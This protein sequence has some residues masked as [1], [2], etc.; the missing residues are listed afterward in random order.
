MLKKPMAIKR[1]SAQTACWY[2]FDTLTRLMA[3]I[4]SFTAEQISDYYQKNKKESIHLQKFADM[5][6]IMRLV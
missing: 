4:M 1:R 3:P 5:G 2:I 6:P